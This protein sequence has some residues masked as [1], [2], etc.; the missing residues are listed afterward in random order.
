MFLLAHLEIILTHLGQR[1]E[2]ACLLCFSNAA[3]QVKL[4][5]TVNGGP[6]QIHYIKWQILLACIDLLQLQSCF[7]VSAVE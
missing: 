6:L 4:R 2:F 7:N 5:S 3:L 1:G